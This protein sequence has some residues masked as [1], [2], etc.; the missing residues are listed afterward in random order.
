[1]KLFLTTAFFLAAPALALAASDVSSLTPAFKG[2]IVSTYP[3]GRQ[4]KLWLSED[5]S[6]TASGRR[7][8]RSSGHW[9]LKGDEVCLSQ[10]HPLPSPFA[11]CTPKPTATAWNAKAVSGE[12]I[13]VKVVKGGRSS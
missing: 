9:K 10:A 2:T 12:P 7:G 4:G 1:M 3:D 8:D 6:Y 11:F 13:K 5:G